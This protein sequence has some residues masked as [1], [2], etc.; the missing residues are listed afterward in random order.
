MAEAREVEFFFDEEVVMGSKVV[1][2]K[3]WVG[4]GSTE[5]AEEAEYRAYASLLGIEPSA[6]SR[7]SPDGPRK[8]KVSKAEVARLRAFAALAPSVDDD[9]YYEKHRA[10]ILGVAR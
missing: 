4:K 7:P 9:A 10:T 1:E 5:A 3:S 6:P 2:Y 8:V